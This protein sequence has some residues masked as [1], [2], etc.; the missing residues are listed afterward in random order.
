[1]GRLGKISVGLR[2]GRAVVKRPGKL[3]FRF[4][5]FGLDWEARVL[6][7]SHRILKNGKHESMAVCFYNHRVMYFAANL[8]HEQFRTTLAHEIQHAI[9]DHAAVDYEKGVH[10]DVHDRWTDQVA[11]GWLYVMR[12][13]P[14]I[15]EF[16]QAK[17]WIKVKK[18]KR[19]D[20][21]G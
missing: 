1:M 7:P 16:L 11:L 14:L 18:P 3:W 2:S 12:H 9:E 6:Q 5:L 21:S 10:V 17:S 4:F 8:T 20:A 19:K 15:V 13:N